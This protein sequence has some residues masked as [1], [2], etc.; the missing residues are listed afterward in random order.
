VTGEWLVVSFRR[1]KGGGN[2]NH[3]GG[4]KIKNQENRGFYSFFEK[5]GGWR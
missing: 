5:W 4:K 3:M 2:F 1:I